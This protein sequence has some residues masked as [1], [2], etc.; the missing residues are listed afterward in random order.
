MASTPIPA[1]AQAASNALSGGTWV[2][3]PGGTQTSATTQFDYA[4]TKQ[5]LN[6]QYTRNPTQTIK[7]NTVTPYRSLAVVSGTDEYNVYNTA[8]HY[9]ITIHNSCTKI[10]QDYTTSAHYQS[11][12]FAINAIK[13]DKAGFTY[14]DVS[15]PNNVYVFGPQGE[16]ITTQP[17][18]SRVLWDDAV[19]VEYSRTDTGT[20]HALKLQSADSD[21]EN[22]RYGPGN[23]GQGNIGQD[24]DT[25]MINTLA[26]KEDIYNGRQFPFSLPI[27]QPPYEMVGG[28]YSTSS[29]VAFG[30][31]AA[32]ILKL[33][34]FLAQV[35]HTL[36]GYPST[37]YVNLNIIHSNGLNFPVD[38]DMLPDNPYYSASRHDFT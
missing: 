13:Q 2:T 17:Y 30:D 18:I 34:Q 11:Q 35:G 36:G 25:Y 27:S 37:K 15:G 21:I 7:T 9:V 1:P 16:I 20:N 10:Q 8:L 29:E 5:W 23:W 14:G 19:H 26:A 6:I 32:G 28:S 3:G 33:E 31:N 12:K 38:A 24:Y 4:E 22:P